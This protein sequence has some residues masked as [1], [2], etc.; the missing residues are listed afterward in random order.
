VAE[1]IDFDPVDEIGVGTVGPAGQRQFF[2]RATGAGRSVVLFCEKFH[3]QGLVGRIQ[4]LLASQ[5]RELNVGAGPAAPPPAEAGAPEWTIGELGLGF[6]E[7]KS[8]F[9]I[10]AREAPAAGSSPS[11]EEEG[12]GSASGADEGSAEDLSTARFWVDEGQVRTFVSQASSVLSAGRPSCPRCG[13][14]MDPEGHPCPASNGSRP[15]F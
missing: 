12:A 11:E 9:V 14:P 6:H 8:R 15:V 10:V 5:G 2:L 1:Q 3:I 4:Q 13:L 7:S